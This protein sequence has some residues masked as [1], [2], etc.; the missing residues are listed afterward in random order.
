MFDADL[1]AIL[2]RGH[3]RRIVE[4]IN[5]NVNQGHTSWKKSKNKRGTYE[6]PPAHRPWKT[7]DEARATI[8]HIFPLTGKAT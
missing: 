2:R 5:T 4:W 1:K 8:K 7:C 3:A 6:R